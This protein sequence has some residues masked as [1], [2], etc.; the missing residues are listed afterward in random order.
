VLV[1]AAALT[2]CKQKLAESSPAAEPVSSPT[3]PLEK[4]AEV[5]APALQAIARPSGPIQFVDVTAKAGISFRHNSGAFGKKYLPETM[6]SG[7]CFIDY[8]NDGWQDIFL[9]NSMDWPDHATRK[10][11]PALYHNNKDGTFTDVTR[12]SGLAVDVYG[13]GCAV[14]D[15]DN[16]GFDDIYL[17]A[18]GNSHLFRNK[19]NGKFEDVTRK[20]G[21]ESPGFATSA[22]WFDYDN[23][24]KLDLFVSHYVTW[25][26]DKDLNCSLDGKNKS[27]CTP[28][29]YKGESA[30]LYHNKG[31]GVFEDV[32]K[33]A[34]LYD[35]TSKSLGIAMLDY[36]DDGWMD[37]FVANDTQRNK[38]YRNNHDGTFS[39][40]GEMVGVAYGESGGTRA[41][42]GTDAGDYDHSG[43]QGLVVGNFT[44]EGLT[45]YRDDGTGL[46]SDQSLSS[47]IGQPSLNVLTFGSFFFDYNLDGLLDIFALNGHVADDISVLRPTLKYEEA[48]LLFR[49]EGKSKF[50]DVT[51]RM[52]AALQKPIVG[53]GAAY[54]DFDNDGD[55]DLLITTNNGP[56]KLLRNEN[57]NQNDMLRVK[58][59][60]TKSNRDGIG[61]KITLTAPKGGHQFAIVK[62]GSS[63]L[64]Q[65]ELPVTFGLGKPDSTKTV[66]LEVIWPS[67]KKDSITSV[68]PNQSLIVQ[69]GKGVISA[70]PIVFAPL[71]PNKPQP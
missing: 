39:D 57:G 15:F 40:T 11:Y 66:D 41:G 10:S 51:A 21:V 23:D 24:G 31:N 60:G 43:R 37:L 6:G 8:D 44:N 63:Y 26:R 35:P 47:G 4:A 48:P 59:V 17:T 68:K 29:A 52:G 38:L 3:A 49:N 30:T 56:A 34:G 36:D 69:E 45:L 65:S 16:D 19:G 12:E 67:G 64:S 50:A 70:Q 55:L 27:Y 14:G 62:S 2:G 9:V 61:A 7:A 18:V 54:A 53:R 28:D 46:F 58:V 32:T 13:M 1:A 33:R 5:P 25:S 71:T 42:M 20:A 22:I